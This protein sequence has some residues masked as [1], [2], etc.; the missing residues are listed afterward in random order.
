MSPRRRT[1]APRRPS[2][3]ERRADGQRPAQLRLGGLMMILLTGGAAAVLGVLQ[4][5]AQFAA[6]DYEMEARR[7]QELA[8][9]RRDDT[10][11]LQTRLGGLKRDETLREAALGPL[12]MIEPSPDVIG[13]LVLSPS[14]ISEFERAE[15]QARRKLAAERERLDIFREEVF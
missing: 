5:H 1:P 15:R 10:K 12:G 2:R 9:E 6:R 3:R 14:L 13:E 7:V 8:R 4:V 11:K